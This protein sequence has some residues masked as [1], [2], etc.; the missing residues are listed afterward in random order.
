MA[1]GGNA[2]DLIQF[3]IMVHTMIKCKKK[4]HKNRIYLRMNCKRQNQRLNSNVNFT[5]IN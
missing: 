2:M 4:K 3:Q 5:T 1:N